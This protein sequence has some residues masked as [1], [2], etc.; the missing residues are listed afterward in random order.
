VSHELTRMRTNGEGEGVNRQDAKGA[1]GTGGAGAETGGPSRDGRIRTFTGRLVDPLA[2]RE[3]DLSIEDIAHALSMTCRFGGHTRKFYS[4]AEHS[5]R[6]AR[7]LGRLYRPSARELA[8]WGLMHDASEAYLGDVVTPVKRL[9]P[10]YYEAEERLM[11]VVAA[12]WR[13]PWPMPAEVHEHDRRA[14]ATEQ[15]DLVDG[16]VVD[17]VPWAERIKPWTAEDA[18]RLFLVAFGELVMGEQWS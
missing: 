8:R 17:G 6:V 7:M 10:D 4:V 2:M 16:S 13:L 12:K 5:V 3:E 15:R 9:Y 1:K 11:R 18:K 14:L